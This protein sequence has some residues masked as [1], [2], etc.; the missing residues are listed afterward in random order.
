MRRDPWHLP[1]LLN[2][3]GSP[4]LVSTLA[5]PGVI[6]SIG[7]EHWWARLYPNSISFNPLMCKMKLRII[8]TSYSFMGINWEIHWKTESSCWLYYYKKWRGLPVITEHQG[9]SDLINKN[10]FSHTGHP[11]LRCWQD[12]FHTEASLCGLQMAGYSLTVFPD[13]FL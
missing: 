13:I 1:S 3:A 9:L 4:D 10:W 5:F 7:I 11:R 6:T 12:W 8:S 2:S